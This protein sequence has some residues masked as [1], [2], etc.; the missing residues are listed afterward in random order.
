M[1]LLIYRV[2]PA[3]TQV[4]TVGPAD[5]DRERRREA[6]PRRR[7]GLAGFGAPGAPIVP[8]SAASTV[9][10]GGKAGFPQRCHGYDP[11]YIGDGAMRTASGRL[12]AYSREHPR[13][14]ARHAGVR[15][16]ISDGIRA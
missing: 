8:D 1:R 6:I 4:T 16:G 9:I 3:G 15:S 14:T 11:A 2:P 10:P 13:D 7:D 12:T 5:P